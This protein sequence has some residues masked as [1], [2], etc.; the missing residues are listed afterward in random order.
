MLCVCYMHMLETRDM[1]TCRIPMPLGDQPAKYTV[2]QYSASS[3]CQWHII[4]TEV[5]CTLLLFITIFSQLSKH[6][7][8]ICCYLWTM[9]QIFQEFMYVQRNPLMMIN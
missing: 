8:R 1:G 2:A 6:L 5:C 3:Q 4:Y 7:E 9:W